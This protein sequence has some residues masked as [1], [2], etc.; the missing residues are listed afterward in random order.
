MAKSY[1]IF[2]DTA[3]V[4]EIKD[5]VSTGIVDGIATNP[6]KMAQAGR[7]YEDVI[8]DIRKFF[9]GPVALEAISTKAG[10]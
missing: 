3:N 8:C 6:N 5:A 7:R 2:L 10:N 9:D 1:R 4:D